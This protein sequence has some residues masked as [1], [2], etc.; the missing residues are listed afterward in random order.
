M[1]EQKPN[2]LI[3]REILAP[4]WKQFV[5][6]AAES[7]LTFVPSRLALSKR[8]EKRFLRCGRL[9]ALREPRGIGCASCF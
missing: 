6:R 5:V 9:R 1:T 4:Q 2:L 8:A 7:P 3:E